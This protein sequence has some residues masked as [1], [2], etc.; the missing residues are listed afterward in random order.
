[1]SKPFSLTNTRK[2]SRCLAI[3]S[4]IL[5]PF[6][7]VRQLRM[8]LI[9]RECSFSALNDDS[10]WRVECKQFLSHTSSLIYMVVVGNKSLL[11][12]FFLLTVVYTYQDVIY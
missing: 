9:V 1:M 10:D 8:R 5:C 6:H 12:L 3:I 4:L 7:F 2:K 11:S